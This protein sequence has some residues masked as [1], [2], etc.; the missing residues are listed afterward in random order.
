MQ[1]YK[2]GT[3]GDIIYFIYYAL[4]N[5]V[6]GIKF[7]KWWTFF[8]EKLKNFEIS[9]YLKAKYR[10]KVSSIVLSIIRS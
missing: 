9:W 7:K 5:V 10:R 3:I 1:E 6:D 2:K 4:K 8:L